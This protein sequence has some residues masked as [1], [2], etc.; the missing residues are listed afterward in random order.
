MTGV[1]L[2]S[3]DFIV[4]ETFL[5]NFEF[6]LSLPGETNAYH[7]TTSSMLDSWYSFVR[8]ESLVFY[9]RATF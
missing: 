7:D 2:L 5:E 8:F 4:K 1:T 9:L 6:F 3:E